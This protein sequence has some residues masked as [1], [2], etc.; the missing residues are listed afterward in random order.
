MLMAITVKCLSLT[1]S[2]YQTLQLFGRNLL[3]KAPLDTALARTPTAF[4][5]DQDGTQL[6][7]P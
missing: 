5:I 4:D 7:L 1:R 2:L 6:V 3:K